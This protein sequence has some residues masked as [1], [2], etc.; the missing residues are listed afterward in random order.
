MLL[1]SSAPKCQ[2]V[3]A[4]HIVNVELPSGQIA[5][6][7]IHIPQM[8]ATKELGHL[9][10][11][12]ERAINGRSA[13]ERREGLL[14]WV[15]PLIPLRDGLTIVLRLLR[16]SGEREDRRAGERD[17]EQGARESRTKDAHWGASETLD[18]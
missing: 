14:A 11:E 3:A 6:L 15:K 10:F 1:K 7:Q 18:S 2:L 13:D 8:L 12:I 4:A 16:A 17:R 5:E 9:L